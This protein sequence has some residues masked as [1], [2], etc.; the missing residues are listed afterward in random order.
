M[1]LG[2][3]INITNFESLKIESN[4]NLTIQ[5][6]RKEILEELLA[7]EKFYPKQVLAWINRFKTI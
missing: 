1:K 7:W 5:K 2:I 3:T 6:C 4:E